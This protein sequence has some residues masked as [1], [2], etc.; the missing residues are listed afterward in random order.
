MRT[1]RRRSTTSD[2][3]PA[4][5]EATARQPLSVRLIGRASLPGALIV[6]AVALAYAVMLPQVAARMTAADAPR[7]VSIGHGAVMVVDRAW[8]VAG[9]DDA[10]VT[11]LSQDASTLEISAPRPTD[12]LPHETLAAITAEWTAAALEGAVITA[13]RASTTDAGDRAATAVLQEPLSTTQ[14]WVVS[15]GGQEV[16]AVLTSPAATWEAAS[17]S[18]QLVVMSTRFGGDP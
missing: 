5:T 3:R 9:A 12:A 15:D 7:A 1:S 6:A 11:T 18:A 13:P 14:A 8:T 17:H 4:G 16:V 10:G 2:G